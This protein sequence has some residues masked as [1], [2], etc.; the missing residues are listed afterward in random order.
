[1][2]YILDF[3]GVIFDGLRF[4]KD[5]RRV[6]IDHGITHEA[7]ENTY[8]DAKEARKG[9]YELD[10]HLKIIAAEYLT[11]DHGALQRDIMALAG[12][13]RHY[14][15]ADAKTF[16]ADA[17]KKGHALFL[18]SAGDLVFQKEKINASGIF[19]FFDEIAITNASQK[20][21]AIDE[22]K[23]NTGAR[24]IVFIDDNKKV[25]D[26]IKKHH[27][28]VKTVQMARTNRAPRTT[29]ANMCIRNFSEIS[30]LL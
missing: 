11:I 26:D 6:F 2:I 10:A 30:S 13:S 7:Y 22:I 19:S 24:E 3:D 27:P 23:K 12:R 8:H 28:S 15:F 21:F 16:L 17:Q 1:M 20:S 4:K 25:L 9:T 14:I 5:F 18:V 29:S